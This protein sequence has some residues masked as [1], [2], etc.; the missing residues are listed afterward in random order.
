VVKFKLHLAHADNCNIQDQPVYAM[1]LAQQSTP[2][3]NSP[4]ASQL[5]EFVPI[6]SLDPERQQELAKHARCVPL[7]AG[8]KL[9]SIGDQDNHILYLLSG[10]IKLS[11]DDESTILVAGSEHARLPL[12]PYQPR[13]LNAVVVSDAEVVVI[14]R[15]LMDILLTWNPY[16]GYVVDEIDA[17]AYDPDDWMVSILQSPIFQRIPPINIQTMFQKLQSCPVRDN[18]VIFLQGDAGDYYY[19]IQ[20]GTCTV[21]RSQNNDDTVIA[22]L[23]AGQ[24]FGEEALLSNAPRNATVIMQSDGILLR[25]AK[26]D[27]ENLFKQPVVETIS[28]EQAENMYS[29]NPLWLD[30]RLPEEH[31]QS[32][33]EESLNIPLY[34]LRES[35]HELPKDRPCIVYCDNAHR[36]SCAV[37][38]LNANG[39]EAYVLQ[40]GVQTQTDIIE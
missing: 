18:D 32:A 8:S 11:N 39:Y 6:Y 28:L 34:R 1:G 15:N 3:F 23:K 10:E 2:Q 12:D 27:F 9:F 20:K 21:I 40:N 19:L 7:P 33:I 4:S 13:Q 14:D 16:S 35:M 24:G 38:L 37:Y 30:V 31:Y 26:T 29:R 25:L 5:C 17:N 36:S 22:Q